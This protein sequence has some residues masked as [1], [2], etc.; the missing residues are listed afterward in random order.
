MED[1]PILHQIKWQGIAI[2]ITHRKAWPINSFGHIEIKAEQRL[3][4]TETGY[5]S[6]F[7]PNEALAEYDGVIDFVTQWLEV[8]CRSKGWRAHVESLRQPSLFDLD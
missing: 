6:H 2:T 7:M 1:E 5:K 4:M 3:P 8:T